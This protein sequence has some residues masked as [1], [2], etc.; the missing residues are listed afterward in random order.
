MLFVSPT[1]GAGV[2]YTLAELDYETQSVYL[3][4]VLAYDLGDPAMTSTAEVT[5]NVLDLTDELPHFDKEVY[6]VT[7][8]EDAQAGEVIT[9]VNA[10]RSLYRYSI[11]SK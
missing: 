10:G 5:V 3:L 4:T 9:T 1:D 8:K 6:E 11:V 7:V 2:I